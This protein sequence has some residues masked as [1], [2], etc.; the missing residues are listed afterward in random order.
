MSAASLDFNNIVGAG[1]K[2]ESYGKPAQ[3][4]SNEQ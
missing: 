4:N 3:R 2:R 1:E